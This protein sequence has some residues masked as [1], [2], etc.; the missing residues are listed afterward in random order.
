MIMAED[1]TDSWTLNE[2]ELYKTTSQT[3][4]NPLKML[5]ARQ[6]LSEENPVARAQF[7]ADAVLQLSNEDKTLFG[8]IRQTE[9][10]LTMMST[11]ETYVATRHREG[12]LQFPE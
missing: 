7:L 6:G 9:G 11:L 12:N 10:R 4:Y 2:I 5:Y 8:K 1:I 3:S